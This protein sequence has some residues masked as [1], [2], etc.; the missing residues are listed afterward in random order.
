MRGAS[1]VNLMFI[2]YINSLP[3]VMIDADVF[4]YADDTVIVCSG[5]NEQQIVADMRRHLTSASV[6]LGDHCLSL[7][8]GKMKGMFF[9]TA[10][11]LNIVETKHML[12]NDNTIEFLD[13]FKYLGVVLDGQLKFKSHVDYLIGKV[14]P[15]LRMLSR[16]RG[17]I[18]QGTA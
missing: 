16:I 14:T 1:G 13:K 17:Y 2:L 9:G 10:P 3:D 4:L 12:F 8:L 5:T 18:G 6:W 15:K 11:R 7:N